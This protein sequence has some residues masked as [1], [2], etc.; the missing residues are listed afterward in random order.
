MSN[1][2]KRKVHF[3]PCFVP[4][5]PCCLVPRLKSQFRWDEEKNITGPFFLPQSFPSPELTLVP[6]GRM[7]HG[8]VGEI[9]CMSGVFELNKCRKCKCL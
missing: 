2:S 5:L 7:G 3:E 4:S 6:S 1:R 9:P 8:T